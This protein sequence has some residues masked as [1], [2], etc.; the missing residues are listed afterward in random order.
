MWYEYWELGNA[1]TEDAP[2][3]YVDDM[4]ARVGATIGYRIVD[5]RGNVR[6]W[7]WHVFDEP[8]YVVM[9]NDDQAPAHWETVAKRHIIAI[10]AP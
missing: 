9:V 5:E 7:Q 2:E 3:G 6:C 10:T 8:G 1:I 4:A